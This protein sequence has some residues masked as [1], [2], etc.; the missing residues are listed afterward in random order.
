LLNVPDRAFNVADEFSAVAA[1]QFSDLCLVIEDGVFKDLL[2]IFVAYF[3]GFLSW[4]SQM[5]TSIDG[6]VDL[7]I[8]EIFGLVV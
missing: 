8:A 2:Y 6:Q 1:L 7:G 4:R 5:L 3:R